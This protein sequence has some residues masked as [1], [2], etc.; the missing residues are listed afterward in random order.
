MVFTFCSSDLGSEHT[1]VEPVLELECVRFVL[2][3][4]ALLP[5]SLSAQNDK[6]RHFVRPTQQCWLPLL[7]KSIFTYVHE[8]QSS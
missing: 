1:R 2:V 5:E 8:D 4:W 6:Q 7:L 3:V